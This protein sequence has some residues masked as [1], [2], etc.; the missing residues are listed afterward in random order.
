MENY[1]AVEQHKAALA[2]VNVTGASTPKLENMGN[3][4]TSACDP[5][6]HLDGS[7]LSHRALANCSNSG[8]KPIIGKYP[9]TQTH[10][11]FQLYQK[12]LNSKYSA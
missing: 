1:N 9:S 5:T 10:D 12:G 2:T 6:G 3:C 7:F 8:K 4:V 11:L